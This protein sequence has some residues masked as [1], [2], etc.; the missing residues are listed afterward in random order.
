MRLF[1]AA[2][3]PY[4]RIIRIAV[5]ELGLGDRI[6]P[7]ETTLRDPASSLLP[8]NP[9]GRV[10]A[11]VLPDGT[12][13]TET[14]LI[15]LH[16]DRISGRAPLLPLDDLAVLAAYGR[17]SGLLDGIAVWNRE[18]RRPVQERSPGVIALE[19]G[20]A[21]RVADA[22]EAAV[23]QGG[24][25]GPALAGSAAPSPASVHGPSPA[26]VHGPSPASVHGPSPDAARIALACTL[27]YCERRHTVWP[28]RDG[29]PALSAWFDGFA[30]R[31]S[32]QATLPPPS[33]I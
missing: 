30:A 15:L 19:E 22:L 14:P 5:A 16:L 26:S 3:S 27:G 29:R 33:G 25:A 23:A 32:F 10:P 8:H 6:A 13:L 24:F 1:F 28:W 18:L 17:V 7:V 4:A 12:V 21:A 11:L 31:P 2:G 20:R 9:V